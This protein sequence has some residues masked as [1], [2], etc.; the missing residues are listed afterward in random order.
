MKRFLVTLCLTAAA[1]FAFAAP[2]AAGDLRLGAQVGATSAKGG[3]VGVSVAYDLNPALSAEATYDRAF[4]VTRATFTTHG[5]AHSITADRIAD[6]VGVNGVV[7]FPNKSRWT[8]YALAGVGYQSPKGAG[9]E[10]TWTAGGGVRFKLL[11]PI[12]LDGRYRFVEGFT[13]KAPNSVG[14]VGLSIKF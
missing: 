13:S 12:S 5:V 8:P 10:A 6:R 11:G 2:A 1:L 14:T 7:S 3:D 9:S 4:A